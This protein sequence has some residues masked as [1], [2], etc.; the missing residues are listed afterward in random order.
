MEVTLESVC[1]R[2]TGKERARKEQGEE[3]K[4]GRRRKKY[5]RVCN[6]Y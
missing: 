5:L 1:H 3:K 4:N 6:I 2:R